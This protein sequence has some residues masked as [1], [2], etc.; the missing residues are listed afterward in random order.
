MKTIAAHTLTYLA[1][2]LVAF[3]LFDYATGLADPT[4]AALVRQTDDPLVQA[5]VL[6]QPIRGLLFGLV[7]YSLRDSLFPSLCRT[8]NPGC[9]GQFPAV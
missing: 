1:A 7:F 6:F 9:G 2:G 3:S 5:G 4:L 8:K